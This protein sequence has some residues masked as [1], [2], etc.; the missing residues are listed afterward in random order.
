[1]IHSQHRMWAASVAAVVALVVVS[2]GN[3]WSMVLGGALLSTL[4]WKVLLLESDVVLYVVSSLNLSFG[5]DRLLFCSSED[6]CADVWP[7][8][9]LCWVLA[10]DGGSL[11]GCGSWCGAGF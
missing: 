9:I 5:L 11:C 10:M 4:V 3:W 7:V 8:L 1:M 2:I 6:V